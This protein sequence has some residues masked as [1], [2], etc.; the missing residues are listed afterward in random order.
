M[1]FNFWVLIRKSL[2]PFSRAWSFCKRQASLFKKILLGLLC[3]GEVLRTPCSEGHNR[4]RN[5]TLC[6]V[7]YYMES[8]FVHK[9]IYRAICCIDL[10]YLQVNHNLLSCTSRN[11]G[12]LRI[13]YFSK[14]FD[15]LKYFRESRL[16][17]ILVF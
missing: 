12:N 14:L 13:N 15:R 17:S 3:L 6:Q 1:Y 10:N 11:K 5:V 4:S 2:Q 9:L 8:N 16:I 7:E